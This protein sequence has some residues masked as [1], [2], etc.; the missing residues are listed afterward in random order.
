[1]FI[2][3]RNI[4]S[5]MD[6][7]LLNKSL[8]YA[9]VALILA[10]FSLIHVKIGTIDHDFD[11]HFFLNVSKCKADDAIYSRLLSKLENK[12]PN[13][14]IDKRLYELRV[15]VLI[16][17]N[18]SPQIDVDLNAHLDILSLVSHFSINFSKKQWNF[19]DLCHR[20]AL[21]FPNVGQE[22]WIKD[23]LH[24]VTP[25]FI[26]SPIDCFWERSKLMPSLPK[27]PSLSRSFSWKTSRPL[28]LLIGLSNNDSSLLRQVFINSGAASGFLDKPCLDTSDHQCPSYGLNFSFNSS[29]LLHDGCSSYLSKLVKWDRKLI[30]SS[31]SKHLLSYFVLQSPE[32]IST[33]LLLE[34]PLASHASDRLLHLWL[35]TLKDRISTV[36]KNFAILTEG[37]RT[38][39]LSRLKYPLSSTEL[40]VSIAILVIH[41]ILTSRA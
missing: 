13:S 15:F 33:S 28:D 29:A 32:Q 19:H 25:C 20:L 6:D 2:W 16:Q 27:I 36:G 37:D 40:L 41:H 14:I 23:L 39:V 8:K 1:M 18:V 30:L 21:P 4:L 26:S 9:S 7:C 11:A 24:V 31:D 35:D 3:L 38:R 22:N 17:S 12:P 5:C 10:L 34:Q